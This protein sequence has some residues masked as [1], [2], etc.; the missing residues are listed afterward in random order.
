MLDKITFDLNSLNED[1]LYGPP[2]GLRALD[3]E[4]CIP[5][6]EKFA[7]AVK[8]ID[9]TVKI[10]PDASGRIG[11]TKDEYLCTGNT[12]QK[13]FKTVLTKLT[14]LVYVTQINESFFE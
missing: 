6:Q 2:D 7:E 14:S 13:N 10:H 5:A 8:Q 11:C 3:Y 1:G 9:P 12:H 4:F